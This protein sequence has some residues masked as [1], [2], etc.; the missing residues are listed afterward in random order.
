VFYEKGALP[1]ST[2]RNEQ[3]IAT[4]TPADWVSGPA[5][6]AWTYEAYAALPDDGHRY[7][8]VQGVLIM[9]PAP[10]P[11]HQSVVGEIYSCLRERI[12]LTGRGLVYMGP[13]DVELSEHDLF[14]PDVLV[15]L[16]EH[17]HR[18]QKNHFVGAPDLAVEIISPSSTTYDRLTKYEMYRQAGVPE[19]WLVNPI[20]RTIQVFV[21]EGKQY[22]SLGIFTGQQTLR[23]Q[24]V[25]AEDVPAEHFFVWL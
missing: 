6:G 15:V 7:E 24:L 14:Q 16:N 13:L 8:I 3:E 4:V 10:S 23:S 22:R 9:S 5:Q 1:M 17:R 2:V 19:Y 11:E 25:P 12:Q 18:F 21:L 20:R